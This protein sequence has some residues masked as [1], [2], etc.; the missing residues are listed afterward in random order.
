MIPAPRALPI[1]FAALVFLAWHGTDARAGEVSLTWELPTNN[2]D[3]TPLTDLAGCKIHYGLTSGTYTVILDVG[4]TNSVTITNLEGDATYYFTGTAY[5]DAGLGSD[6]CGEVDKIVYAPLPEPPVHDYV[7]FEAESGI[8]TG[9]MSSEQ[10]AGASGG[11]YAHSAVVL[12]GWVWLSF[13]VSGGDY[14]VWARAAAG[15]PFP[16]LHDS[17]LV[18]VDGGAADVWDMFYDRPGGPAT[19]WTW[20]AVSLRAGGT[21]DNNLADPMVLA[22]APGSHTLAIGAFEAGAKLDKI[23]ITTDMA[24]NPA[25]EVSGADADG[26]GQPDAWEL[27]RFGGTDRAGGEAEGDYDGDGT[28]N[29]DEYVVGTDPSSQDGGAWVS[30]RVTD[31][32]PVVSF[33]ALCADGLGYPATARRYYR[34]EQCDDLRWGEWRSVDGFGVLPAMSNAVVECALPDPRGARFFRTK[35]WLRK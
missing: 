10:D 2:V 5:N 31:G 22:L 21:K 24:Y 18:S 33:E 32:T 35:A 27:W 25:D 30:I 26:D 34:L 19:Q 6:F 13:D 28:A 17:F 8:M 14:I 23:L 11:R 7:G 20:D 16:S 12:G 15:W 29:V 9:N 3:G 4:F 1:W